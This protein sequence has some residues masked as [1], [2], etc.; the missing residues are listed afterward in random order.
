MNV[1]FSVNY[2]IEMGAEPKM[3]VLGMP[4]FGTGFILVDAKHVKLHDQANG[5]SP[6][7]F[8]SGEKGYFGYNEV[9]LPQSSIEF[10]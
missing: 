4:F 7:G 3:I 5:Y 1:N 6:A 9:Y 8:I 10:N 2:F